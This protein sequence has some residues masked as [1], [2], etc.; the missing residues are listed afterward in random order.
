MPVMLSDGEPA[1]LRAVSPDDGPA[2]QDFFEQLTPEDIRLRFFAPLRE[3]PD[4]HLERLLNFDPER[5]LAL[6]LDREGEIL[7]IG[8]IACEH[9]RPERAEFAVTVRSDLQGRRIGTWL[10]NRLIDFARERG[11]AE[12]YGDIL[13]E[14]AAMRSVVEELGFRVAPLAET[15]AIHRA[16]RRL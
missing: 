11:V 8:R 4:G 6:V 15:T 1:L 7:A 3:L 5:E 12:L 10:L 9:G 14:N 16:V 2:L 13:A